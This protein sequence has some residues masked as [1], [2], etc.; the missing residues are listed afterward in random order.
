MRAPAVWRGCGQR[1]RPV[2]ERTA[3]PHPPPL[4]S[5]PLFVPSLDVGDWVVVI[6]A[7]HVAL[8]GTKAKT[9]LYR[10]HTGHP[11]GLKTL[12]ARHLF[13]RAPERVLEA[14]VLGMLPKSR[15]HAVWAKKLRI[16]PDETHDHVANVSDSARGTQAYRERYA[17]KPSSLRPKAETGD[18]VVD[19]EEPAAAELK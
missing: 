2:V 7:R 16:F 4:P 5:Q 12:T 19:W 11:G 3:F 10:W 6:N 8:S 9:K 18:L 14:A 13:E 15:L 17:P 1:C